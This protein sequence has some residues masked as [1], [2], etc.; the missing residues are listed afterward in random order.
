MKIPSVAAVE[1]KAELDGPNPPF[2]LDVRDAEELEISRLRDVV[3][4]PLIEL[5]ARMKELNPQENWV[6]VCRSGTRS[7]HATAFL[8]QH[9]FA[10]VRNLT[11]GMNGWARTVDP[12]LPLY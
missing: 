3:N 10:M 5:S 4:I 9:G 1:L 6:V 11:D 8:L 2:I 12:S 7:G